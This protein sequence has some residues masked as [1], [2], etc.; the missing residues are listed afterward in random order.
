M[1]PDT[2][3][4]PKRSASG[5][6]PRPITVVAA[7]LGLKQADIEPYGSNKAKIALG[8]YERFAEKPD[9]KL[10]LVTAMTPTPAGEGKT[11]MTIGL[12][13]ALKIIGHRP[14]VCLREPSMGPVFGVKGG[15][16]GGGRAK[17]IPLE[18]IN[19]H[20]T[21]DLHA[22]TSAHN[23]L[24]SMIDNHLM[25]GNALGLDP[26]RIQF[27]RV[28]DMNDRALRTVVTGLGGTANGWVRETGFDITA[29]SE[30]MA[31]LCLATDIADLKKRLG[32]ILIGF[33]G[34]GTP[35]FARD[36]HA[37][38]AMAAILRDAIKPNL[39]QTAEG[40]PA[41]IHGGPFANIAHGCNSLTATRLALKLGDVVLTE[42]G[43][44]TELGAEKFFDIKCR[45]AGLEP[46]AV[47][48]VATV[49]ALK[50]HGGVPKADLSREHMAELS[51]GFEN[52]AKHIE[53]IR[54]FNLPAI[55]AI[56][57]FPDDTDA[58]IEWV[59]KAVEEADCSAAVSTAY[60]DGGEGSLELARKVDE[61]LRGRHQEYQPLYPLE[62]PLVEKINVVARSC[63]GAAAVEILEPAKKALAQFEQMGCGDLPVCMAKTQHS[64]SDVPGLLGRPRGFKVTVREARLSA[65]A[66]FIVALAG[67][68]MTMPGL[69]K[70]PAAERIDVDNTG[71]ITGL[72]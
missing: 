7:D 46:Q 63:Y 11:T 25:Q 16:A 47:V 58:E 69:P 62:M 38:G 15:A 17:V 28:M 27:R 53:N 42:A 1:N 71:R 3:K 23:L 22:V 5:P 72:F 20:F 48:I 52:L 44:A 24:A 34:S 37:Q 13:D 67:E 66:G 8:V 40:T 21:G 59:R 35:V 70:Q 49:R 32:N 57:R 55:V 10:V 43:F 61:I 9:A 29:A 56:N 41:F 31:I 60:Q 51:R 12:A 68:I 30:V 54:M 2:E 18:E 26:R 39:V 65:G 19:L 6:L 14:V 50:L 45:T 4:R 64:L 33:T 36:L